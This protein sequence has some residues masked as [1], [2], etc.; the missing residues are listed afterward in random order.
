MTEAVVR[1]DGGL[2][3]PREWTR[4]VLCER[5]LLLDWR[6]YRVGG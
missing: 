2:D 4:A 3:Q 5:V 1:G 6:N